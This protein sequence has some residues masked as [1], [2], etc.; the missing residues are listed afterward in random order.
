MKKIILYLL[1][2]IPIFSFAQNEKVTWDYPVKSGSEEWKTLKNQKEK[3][4]ICQIPEEILKNISTLELMEI[5][6][7]YPLIYDALTFHTIQFGMDQLR[8]NFNGFDELMKRDNIADLLIYRYSNF[9]PKGYNKNWTDIQK[10]Y[11]SLE[12]IVTEIFLSQDDVISKMTL[13][14]KKEL[15]QL[16]LLKQAEK[17]DK[18]IYDRMSHISIGFALAKILRSSGFSME[19]YTKETKADIEAFSTHGNFQNTQILPYLLES[20][21]EFTLKY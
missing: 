1:I 20:A 12:I 19:K 8:I 5:C 15:V 4:A 11:F 6:F 7:K 17:E 9:H 10:G 18:E 2:T 13:P 14:Q 21:K 16:L 3:L